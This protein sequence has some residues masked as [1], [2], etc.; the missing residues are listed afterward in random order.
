MS[1][2]SCVPQEERLVGRGVL[3]IANHGN[4]LIG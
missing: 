1:G 2:A 3:L 4:R